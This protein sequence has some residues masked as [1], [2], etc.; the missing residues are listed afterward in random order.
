MADL[1]SFSDEE[2]LRISGG[3]QGGSGDLSS[4]SDEELRRIAGFGVPKAPPGLFGTATAAVQGANRGVSDTFGAVGDLYN[5][6][7]GK[8]FAKTVTGREQT[9]GLPIGSEALRTVLN[10]ATTVAQ[11]ATGIGQPGV[12]ATYDNINDLPD[13]LRATARAGEVAGSTLAMLMP[14][15][16]GARFGTTPAQVLANEARYATAVP[17]ARTAS[18]GL[19][20]M[21]DQAASNPAAC[22]QQSAQTTASKLAE[23]LSVWIARSD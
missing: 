23:E 12:K 7:I 14:F 10:A 13:H 4:M 17:S 21:V 8:P 9:R 22:A 16:A 15:A 19:G 6:Y 3:Q 18:G 5:E 2:L 20:A 1:S 11:K